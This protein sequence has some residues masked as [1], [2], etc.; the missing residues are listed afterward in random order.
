[1][2]NN[3]KC[4]P[5]F[6]TDFALKFYKFS[7]A[8][9]RKLILRTIAHYEGGYYWSSTLRRIFFEVY[10]IK[11]GMGSYGCFDPERFPKNTTIG[12]YCSIAKGVRYFNAN[13]PMSE[14]TMHP[15][16]YNP[17]L[18]Y[19]KEDKLKR[20]KLT[21]GHD[22][23]IG[24]GTTILPNCTSIGNG[25]VIGAN[26]VVSRNVPPYAIVAGAPAKPIR[27]RF[28]KDTIKAL[29]GSRWFEL[30]PWEIFKL[31][32]VVN[33]PSVFAERAFTLTKDLLNHPK[34]KD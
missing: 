15:M 5:K 18:G 34:T 33:Q 20:N 14:S 19:V 24:Y 17:A 8:K 31:I 3:F 27:K 32:E 21:I 11:I 28:D 7:P 16:F 13:H 22:V 9:L 23:W 4:I 26:S 1:M 12:N 30:P 10:G 25:A 6:L 2:M 29:E